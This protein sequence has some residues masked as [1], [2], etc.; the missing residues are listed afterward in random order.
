MDQPRH[1][2]N[3]PR[4]YLNVVL[5]AIAVL[6][7]LLVLDGRGARDWSSEARAQ[8]GSPPDDP[9]ASGQAMVSASEQRKTMIAELRRVASRLE[10]IESKLAT[11]INVKVTEMPAQK[12]DGK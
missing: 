7:A 12:Q 9:G 8:V 6:L 3:R 5:T 1:N 11:G 4:A 10:R 2:T